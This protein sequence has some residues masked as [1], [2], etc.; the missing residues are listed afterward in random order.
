MNLTC[1]LGEVGRE[2]GANGA[3]TVVRWL[4]LDHESVTSL[5][6]WRAFVDE[7]SS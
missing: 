3:P 5:S 2:G 6:L 4:L 1:S 7:D